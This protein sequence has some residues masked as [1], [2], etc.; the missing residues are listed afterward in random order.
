MSRPTY[1]FTNRAKIEV[2]GKENGP[3]VVTLD[4]GTVRATAIFEG[5]DALN[6]LAYPIIDTYDGVPLDY[7]AKE[8]KRLKV[9]DVLRATMKNL[10]FTQTNDD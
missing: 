4:D 3:I 7:H 8:S 10:G 6:H 1:C 9:D 5:L 2:T